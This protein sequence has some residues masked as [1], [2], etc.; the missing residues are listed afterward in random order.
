MKK[1]FITASKI[2]ILL[3]ALSM[4]AMQIGVLLPLR[5]A[6]RGESGTDIGGGFV[7]ACIL[8]SGL[9]GIIG[10]I[11]A[12]VAGVRQEAPATVFSMV[13]K[14]MMIPFFI[15]NFLFWVFLFLGTLNP[16]LIVATPFVVL[17]G[18]FLTYLV[19]LMTSLPDVIFTL[20]ELRLYKGCPK[21]LFVLGIVFSFFFVLDVVGAV[22][23]HIAYK[24]AER[25]RLIP[26]NEYR[27][28][29]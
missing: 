28:N 4:Y 26:G 20:I 2:F 8:F 12:I 18:G 1:T 19:V 22:I 5:F 11:L 15:L 3:G 13:L 16:F 10:L 17:I 25:Y 9:F 6:L 23:L 14:F 7:L 27:Q 29:I 21:K 24:K